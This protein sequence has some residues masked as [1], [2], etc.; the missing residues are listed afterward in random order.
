[1]TR[2]FRWLLEQR[3]QH[4][5]DFDERGQ[6]LN[7][8]SARDALGAVLLTL[9]L[10]SFAVHQLQLP[11]DEAAG[12]VVSATLLVG[13]AVC[14]G[15]MRVRGFLTREVAVRTAVV[16]LACT[17]PGYIAWQPLVALV[18]GGSLDA[19]RFS[20]VRGL[21]VFPAMLTACGVLLLFSRKDRESP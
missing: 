16:W 4:L 6:L 17:I 20:A 3:S 14:I 10:S 9:L 21:L 11:R 8:L 19:I 12:L 15:S 18:S 1:L 13:A 5:R 7:A 2:F